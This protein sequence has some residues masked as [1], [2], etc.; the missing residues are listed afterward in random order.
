MN[1]VTRILEF[2]LIQGQRLI[3]STDPPPQRPSVQDL[4]ELDRGGTPATPRMRAVKWLLE[5][6]TPDPAVLATIHPGPPVALT[7]SQAEELKALNGASADAA[8]TL[9]LL[10]FWRLTTASSAAGKKWSLL[11]GVPDSTV[12][13]PEVVAVNVPAH[14]FNDYKTSVLRVPTTM[15]GVGP[16]DY[17]RMWAQSKNPSL[18]FALKLGLLPPVPRLRAKFTLMAIDIA[19]AW[20]ATTVQLVKHQLQV[21]RPDAPVFSA[22]IQPTLPVPAFTAYPGGHAA[23]ATTVAELL[24]AIACR[25]DTAAATELRAY[26]AQ[27]SL[28]REMAGLHCDLDTAA[29]THLGAEMAKSLVAAAAASKDGGDFISWSAIFAQA[30]QEWT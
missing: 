4:E 16:N 24:V 2:G 15:S 20:V 5:Q 23:A 21:P 12:Q 11:G 1:L 22:G 13:L 25:Q 14:S 6:S 28:N 8:S 30:Q 19:A 3:T 17:W 7:T 10:P 29:G 18:G 9:A 27:I 26:A